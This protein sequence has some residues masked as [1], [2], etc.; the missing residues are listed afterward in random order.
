MPGNRCSNCISRSFE[1]AYV[2]EA[3]VRF[4]QAVEVFTLIVLQKRSPPNR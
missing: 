1:C 3:K 2:E 4:L